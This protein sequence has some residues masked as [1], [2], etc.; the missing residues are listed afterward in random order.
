MRNQF[1]VYLLLFFTIPLFLNISVSADHEVETEVENRMERK[2]K[3]TREFMET[4]KQD[5]LIQ[6]AASSEIKLKR[7]EMKQNAET[8][9]E[10]MKQKREESKSRFELQREEFKERINTIKDEQKKTLIENIDEKINEMNIQHT[11]RLAQVLSKVDD[12]L[13]RLEEKITDL[14]QKSI[15]TAEAEKA[16]TEA[17]TVIQTASDAITV[18]AGKQYVIRIS[19]SDESNLRDEVKK[20]YTIFKADITAVHE[21]VKAARQAVVNVARLYGQ[22]HKKEQLSVTPDVTATVVPTVT[23]TP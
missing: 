15:D 22:L 5:I 9:R 19:D 18:Q 3:E 2:T 11:D 14:K 17:K 6:K 12:I 13:S 16:V 7:E 10:D 4:K 1:L 8:L 23:T 20:T 21:K